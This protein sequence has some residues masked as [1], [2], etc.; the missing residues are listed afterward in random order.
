M[1]RLLAVLTLLLACL[2]G[3]PATAIATTSAPAPLGG[4]SVLFHPS[5][6]GRCTAAFAAY[7]STSTGYLIAGPGCT[8]GTSTLLYSGNNVLVGPIVAAPT[9]FGGY[10]VVRVTNTAAW[11]LVP[12]LDTGSGRIVI[13]GSVET[14]VGGSVC[15]IDRTTGL[16]CG[17]II[18]K[19]VTVAYPWGTVSGL[20]RTN[21]CVQPGAIGTAYVS[22]DQAQGVPLGGS[23]SC[24]IAGS[25]YFQPV[26]KILAAYGLRLLT[27]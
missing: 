25:S 24:T 1:Q 21:I 9:P 3:S 20:T 7:D 18:A 6:S 16:R 14:P 13:R 15:L 23:G 5:G 2:L 26:N 17:T 10:V 19:N 11:Q 22:G 4:G 8:A 12:W 27:G